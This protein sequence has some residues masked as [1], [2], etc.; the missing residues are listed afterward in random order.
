LLYGARGF[1]VE[2]SK[3]LLVPSSNR[4]IASCT[5]GAPFSSVISIDRNLQ[6]LAE[7]SLLEARE[8][9]RASVIFRHLVMLLQRNRE[10]ALRGL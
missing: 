8:D 3:D 9:A 1:G 2:D 5:R 6:I 4:A 10:V 7:V